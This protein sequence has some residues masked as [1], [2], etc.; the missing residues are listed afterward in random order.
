MWVPK[1]PNV[2]RSTYAVV[3]ALLSILFHSG[4]LEFL[5]DGLRPEYLLLLGSPAAAAV[6][7]KWFTVTKVENGAVVKAPAP[8]NPLPT[9]TLVDTLTNDQGRADLFDFQYFLFNVVA[10][11]Y[12]FVVFLPQPENGLPDLPE[13]LVALTSVSAAS[14]LTKKGLESDVGPT[15]TAVYP[16]LIVFGK[17]EWILIS[18]INFGD[19]D[20]KTPPMNTVL[21]G[22][23]NLEAEEW[24]PERIKAKVPDRTEAQAQ[25]FTLPSSVDLIVQDR[26]GRRS[27]PGQQKVSLV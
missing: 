14:Y 23:R 25:G 5:E 27:T 10:L 7:A 24:T 13:T 1:L 2:Q 18:G 15:I 9:Q 4:G 21:L 19:Q 8:D 26:Y 11:I 3:F 22:G 17:D 16:G 12:F 6:L 20:T